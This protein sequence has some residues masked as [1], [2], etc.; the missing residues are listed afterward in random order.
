[1]LIVGTIAA[2]FMGKVDFSGVRDEAWVHV[3]H[4][5]YF[6]MPTFDLTAI[7]T[8]FLVLLV[9][10]VESTGVYF[11]VSDICKEEVT[12]KDLA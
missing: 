9:G 4:F 6:G 5:F 12:E 3:P 7:L 10:I 8:M 1:G 11:A 2:S